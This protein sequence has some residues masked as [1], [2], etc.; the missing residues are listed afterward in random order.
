[1]KKPESN[2]IKDWHPYL[3]EIGLVAI[4][5]KQRIASVWAVLCMLPPG[6]YAMKASMRGHADP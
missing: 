6:T 1:M 2:A 3:S 4:S 5:K